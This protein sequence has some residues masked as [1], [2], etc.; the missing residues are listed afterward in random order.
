VL[1]GEAFGTTYSVKV[2]PPSEEGDRAPLLA[3]IEAEIAQVN[4]CMST[5]IKESELS[6]LNRNPALGPLP[7]SGMLAEVLDEA[8]RVH[9]LSEG[10]FDITVGP[11]INAWGF[12]PDEVV[13]P[14]SPDVIDRARAQVGA[15]ALKLDLSAGTLT[16]TRAG[17]LIDVSAIGKGYGV[18]RIGLALETLGYTRYLAEIG[19]EVRAR[20]L[21]NSGKPWVVGVESPDGG[22]QDVAEKVA[23]LDLSIAT[24]G[25][26]RNFRTVDGKT[27]THIVDARNGQPVS[28]LLGSVSVLQ[29]TC[30]RAD[31][32]A[33]AF[34][35]LGDQKGYEIAEREGIPALF[36][37]ASSEG[38]PALR[39]ATSAYERILAARK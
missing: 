36:L 33:T 6:R 13:K 30:M 16:R 25:N 22:R 14:P 31:A 38:R 28:H 5:Y 27:I 11:L 37:T 26:Y 1:S 8:G 23:L 29:P 7:I 4:A 15:D 32:L 17:L 34:Y 3:A 24:S 18:D 20:G 12:G 2:I 19:G 9:K 39:R 10:A 35:V 21:N